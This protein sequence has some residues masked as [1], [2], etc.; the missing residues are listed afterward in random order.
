[1]SVVAGERNA[2]RQPDGGRGLG[3]RRI[4]RFGLQL[5]GRF[6]PLRMGEFFV[7]LLSVHCSFSIWVPGSPY[8]EQSSESSGEDMPVVDAEDGNDESEE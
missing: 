8:N 1:M 4:R 2:R 3:R 6:S 5:R 7:L